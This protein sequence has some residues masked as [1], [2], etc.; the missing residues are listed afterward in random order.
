MIRHIVEFRLQSSDAA[1]RNRDAE[2]IRERLT[3]L[4]GVIPGLRRLDVHRDLGRV[5]NHWDVVLVSDHDDNA[6]LETYQAHPAHQ[7]ASAWISTVVSDRAVVDFE[8]AG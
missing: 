5:E 4:V 3:A 1:Q 6:A 8:M 2:G 7:E